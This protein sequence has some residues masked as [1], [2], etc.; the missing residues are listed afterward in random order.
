[1]NIRLS[2]TAVALALFCAGA[3]AAQT[4]APIPEKRPHGFA[5][6]SISPDGTSVLSRRLT[7]RPAQV[8]F[9]RRRW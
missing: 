8:R 9:R 1:M 7:P 3:V 5:S 2:L 6:V 4:T